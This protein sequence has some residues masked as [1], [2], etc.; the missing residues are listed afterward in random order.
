MTH[1]SLADLRPLFERALPLLQHPWLVER[2]A[3]FMVT[4]T[5]RMEPYAK[6]EEPWKSYRR[7][8]FT[9]HSALRAVANNV[10]HLNHYLSLSHVLAAE[11]PNE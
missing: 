3:E 9:V 1:P 7:L 11:T 4:G 8:D 2:V 6:G 5:V 10:L